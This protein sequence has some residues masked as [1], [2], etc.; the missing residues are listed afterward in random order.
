MD[1]ISSPPTTSN[2]LF[3][4][5]LTILSWAY[6]GKY[7]R[8]VPGGGTGFSVGGSDT[9]G[10][11]YNEFSFEDDE[12]PVVVTPHVY[13]P[14]PSSPEEDWPVVKYTVKIERS[15]QVSFFR[16]SRGEGGADSCPFDLKR[17]SCSFNISALLFLQALR[18]GLHHDADIAERHRVQRVL[19]TALLRRAV[20]FAKH[21]R[22]LLSVLINE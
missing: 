10:Q 18:E 22:V 5:V 8:P 21:L 19:A 11:S 16:R 4:H 14:Y 17:Y 9:A 2:V 1:G 20:S 6:S 15:W 3:F 7:L 13:P 12:P